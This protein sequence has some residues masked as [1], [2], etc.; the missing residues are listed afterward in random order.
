MAAWNEGMREELWGL[1]VRYGAALGEE[2]E[3]PL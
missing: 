3:T 1:T 2:V